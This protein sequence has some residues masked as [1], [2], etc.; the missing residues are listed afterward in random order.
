MTSPEDVAV[1]VARRIGAVGGVSA[2]VLGGSRARGDADKRSDVDLGI[3]Y[4]PA[5]PPDVRALR[6]LARDLDDRHPDD[7]LTEIGAWGPW[8]NGGGWLTIGG[9]RVDWLYRD[10]ARMAEVFAEC[11]AG[12]PSCH[13]HPGYPHGF[14]SHIYLAEA[15]HGRA[16]VAR[17]GAFE[18]LRARTTPYPERL[19]AALMRT[20]LWEAGFTVENAW[21]PAHR[22]EIAFV[23]GCLHR[24]AACLLQVLFARNRTYF[25][26]EKRA[27]AIA[28]GFAVAPPGFAATVAE[29]LAAPGATP[30]ALVAQ[31]ARA[32]ALVE[33]VRALMARDGP[34]GARGDV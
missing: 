7:P 33:A 3:Y 31:V 8:M 30:E 5:R 20:H 4:H 32:A 6:A 18:A 22:G 17:D 2:V 10:L 15:H 28:E 13:Y 29:I 12:R 34:P 14:H 21:N 9:V 26:H 24:T 1:D 23:A 11:E 16:L 25:L 19:A 27:M